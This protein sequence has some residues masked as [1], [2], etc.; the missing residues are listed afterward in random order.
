MDGGKSLAAC[1]IHLAAWSLV[2]R[3]SY[4]G[5][6][7]AGV[8]F[9]A[10]RPAAIA[11]TPPASPRDADT[12]AAAEAPT[13]SILWPGILDPALRRQLLGAGPRAASGATLA[14]GGSGMS[15]QTWGPTSLVTVSSRRSQKGGGGVAW[16]ARSD[17]CTRGRHRAPHCRTG[18]GAGRVR[19]QRRGN[20]GRRG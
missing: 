15:M 10:H 12:E 18:Q 3:P 9:H 6:L 4:E 14:T 5:V 7:W 17:S 20:G 11:A 13:P 19:A 16:P 2:R 1:E 8:V